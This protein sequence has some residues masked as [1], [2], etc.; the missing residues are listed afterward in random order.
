MLR[1]KGETA[2]LAAVPE[3]DENDELALTTAEAAV[4]FKLI[5]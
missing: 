1:T 2:Y 5:A 3:F 4:C